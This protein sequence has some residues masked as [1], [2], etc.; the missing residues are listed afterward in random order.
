MSQAN[1][2][3]AVVSTEPLLSANSKTVF[4]AFEPESSCVIDVIGGI[5][6]LNVGAL[7][8]EPEV[9]VYAPETIVVPSE[10]SH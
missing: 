10:F 2:P 9:I 3:N 6:R 5:E 4:A 8:H 7:E 1:N